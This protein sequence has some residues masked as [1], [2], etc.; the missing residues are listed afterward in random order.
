MAAGPRLWQASLTL[1]KEEG[2]ACHLYHSPEVSGTQVGSGFAAR[3]HPPCPRPGFLC[4]L[5]TKMAQTWLQAAWPPCCRPGCGECCRHVTPEDGHCTAPRWPLSE[6]SELPECHCP[7]LW[8]SLDT[9]ANSRK[10]SLE[11]GNRAS[12]GGSCF[13]KCHH[14]N[15]EPERQDLGLVWTTAL[16]IS[17]LFFSVFPTSFYS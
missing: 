6:S 1:G 7:A 14:K 15:L 10:G 16:G 13:Q 17:C 11:K 8:G 3:P 2:G 9:E 4:C 5:G 12:V